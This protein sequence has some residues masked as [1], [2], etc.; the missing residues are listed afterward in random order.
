VNKTKRKVVH[1]L[2]T[3]YKHLTNYWLGRCISTGNRLRGLG[4]SN[5]ELREHQYRSNIQSHCYNIFLNRDWQ[6]S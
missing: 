4:G 6:W 1:F 5:T 3:V 2:D